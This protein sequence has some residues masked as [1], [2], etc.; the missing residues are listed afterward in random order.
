MP[1]QL[2]ELVGA[3]PARRF[4]P[5]CWRIRMALAHKGLAADVV[6]WRF[7]ETDRLAFA[8]T[9]KVP[10]LV[11][12]ARVLHDSGPIAEYLDATYPDAP[13]LFGGD[14]AARRFVLAWTNTVLHPA[15]VRLIVSDIPAVL[16]PHARAYFV[17][18]RE[19]RFGMT[20][21]QV[22]AGREERLAAFHALLAPLR[23]VLGEQD[24]LGGAAPDYG[25]YAV[26]GAFQWARCTSAFGL[27]APGDAVHGWRA[28]MLELF[29]GLAREVPAFD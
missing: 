22:T 14:I 4:S 15:I 20:L 6:P 3:D 21:A 19:A 8:G 5:Y 23:Q 10:V 13:A 17:A 11:D 26:F 2:Y 18:N 24:F 9:D 29:G 28:R 12:G 25:D 7:T 27:L 16:D 1:R